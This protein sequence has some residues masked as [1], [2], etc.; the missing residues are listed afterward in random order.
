[1]KGVKKISKVLTGVLRQLTDDRATRELNRLAKLPRY[2]ESSTEVL[3]DTLY[4]PDAASFVA[5]YREIFK[6]KLY[7]FHT[8]ERVP[9]IIDCGANIGM[10]VIFFKQL[11]PDSSV[12]AFEPDP[13]IFSILKKNIESFRL[14]GVELLNKGLWSSDA[15]LDFASEGADSGRVESS[16]GAS[17]TISVEL[18]SLRPYL[19]QR[20]D[21]LKIDIEGAEVEVLQDCSSLLSNV[22]NIFVEFHSFENR[23]QALGKT[24]NILEN[25]GFRLY[26]DAN[27]ARSRT[28]FIQREIYNGMDMQL[29]IFGFRGSQILHDQN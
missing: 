12:I 6:R 17:G 4:F 14:S 3:G 24:I 18:V 8:Q 26:L 2:Q 28:P 20:V 21:F 25:A 27:G 5:M 19:Q 23:S 9:L 22:S 16:S 7:T 10:S 29:N 15:T 1:M 11:Y 13:R